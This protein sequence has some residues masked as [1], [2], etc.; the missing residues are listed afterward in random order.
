MNRIQ[1]YRLISI[2]GAFLVGFWLPI[3]MIGFV[4]PLYLEV[5]FDLLVSAVSLINIYLYFYDTEK[6]PKE[7]G[8]WA[9]VSLHLDLICVLPFSL[10]A[11]VVFDETW[12]WAMVINLLSVRHIRNIRKFLDGFPSLQPVTY[13]LVPLVITLPLLVHLVSCGWIALGSGTAGNDAD[14]VL[15]YVKAVYWSF[16]TLTTVGYGDIS[17]KSI[18]Q[19]LFTCGIQVLGVGVF[20]F[21]LSNVASILARTDAAREHHM[22]N[23]DK[24]ETFMKLHHTPQNLRSKI[25]TYYHYMWINKKGYQDDSLLDGLPGKIQSELFMH[26]NRSIAEKVPFLRDAGAELLEEL[27]SELKPRIYIP[28]EK[29]FKIDE[30]GD[31]LYF[32]QSGSVDILSREGKKLATLKDGAF[33][34]EIALISDKPRSATARAHSFCD[35]YMLE[36]SAFDRVTASYPEFRHHVEEIMNQR[37]VA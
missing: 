16:T 8:S 12:A 2:T 24:I 25:R 30:P 15:T 32:I 22:D 33:F 11:L 35:V 37:Q 29:I 7:L 9:A 31:A 20:G 10:A 23:L 36:R 27:M 3:R 4:P 18:P 14:Q 5:A 21:I 34:G 26:I 28:D 6:D 19:M 17:A 1:F 13:R